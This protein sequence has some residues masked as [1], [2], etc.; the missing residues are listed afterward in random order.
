MNTRIFTTG[1]LACAVFL[2]GA[3]Q[4]AEQAADPYPPVKFDLPEHQA[5]VDSLKLDPAR[6]QGPQTKEE[7][8]AVLNE[9]ILLTKP[10]FGKKKNTS[11]LYSE[12]EIKLFLG[13]IQ[14]SEDISWK[15]AELKRML[16]FTRKYDSKKSRNRLK[17]PF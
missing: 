13:L 11:D 17:C 10:F 1:A 4:A 3:A 14:F 2:A 7:I 15:E 8:K 16:L 12:M 6:H 5:F 9:A